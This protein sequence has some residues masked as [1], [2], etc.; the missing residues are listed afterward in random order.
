M[1]LRLNE[2]FSLLMYFIAVIVFV[3]LCV[4][5][6][7]F[8]RRPEFGFIWSY[9]T[10]EVQRVDGV[11]AEQAG[12]TAGSRI[13]T[14][15]GLPVSE[16]RGV[17]GSLP[18]DRVMIVLNQGNGQE[19][20][21]SLVLAPPSSTE[22]VNRLIVVFI[23]FSYWAL[24]LSVAVFGRLSLPVVLFF[25]S[26]QLVAGILGAGAVSAFTPILVG[27]V[28]VVLFWAISPVLLHLHFELF[29][30]ESRW[31][32]RII[33][34]SY[35]LTAVLAVSDI[36]LTNTNQGEFIK[37]FQAIWFI[38]H[39]IGVVVIT[40][41]VFV[42]KHPVEKRRT[43]ALISLSVFFGFMPLV[44]F[45]ML[46]E[47][48]T[49]QRLAEYDVSLISLSIV[50]LGYSYAILRHR[51][52]RFDRYVNRS[53]A[54]FLSAVLV[55]GIYVIVYSVLQN[56]SEAREGFRPVL[57]FLIPLALSFLV[58]PLFRLTQ[59][60]INHMF[61]GEWFDDMAIVKYV[62]RSIDN[63][64]VGKLNLGANLCQT[65]VTTLGLENARLVL[66]DGQMVSS[67]GSSSSSTEGEVVTIDVDQFHSLC[68]ALVQHAGQ[69]MGQ[70]S[71]ALTLESV[72]QIPQ[73]KILFERAK[74][75]FL[76]RSGN[77]VL[78]LL[79]LG[80]KRGG[81]EYSAK[82][83]EVL[84]VSLMQARAILENAYLI[85]ELELQAENIKKLH[86][87]VM[88]SREEERKRIARDLHDQTIQALVG[89]NYQIERVRSSKG[90]ADEE[91]MRYF[92]QEVKKMLDEVRQICSALRPPALDSVGLAPAIQ[93][94][95]EELTRGHNIDIHFSLEGYEDDVE[96]ER[97]MFCL[98]RVFQ[99]A[100]TNVIKH[101]EAKNAY[102]S[103]TFDDDAMVLVVEDDGRGFEVPRNLG[104]LIH[105]RHFGLI[106]IQEMVET[107][108]GELCIE[109]TPGEG[110][111]VIARVPCA[112][113]S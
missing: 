46:P 56:L 111:K 44:L 96:S 106:G 72:E 38:L 113:I 45:S 89:F 22:V 70:V 53:A 40:L 14:I 62:S 105:Q 24:G 97:A 81:G 35:V 28:F 93:S 103:L 39:L 100:T 99:E 30:S 15:D 61:Y 88:L 104:H 6:Y 54:L 13:I 63:P 8:V 78:G 110:C 59:G 87:E 92:Q 1:I 83:L 109:S 31:L 64:S 25:F 12:I 10:G 4:S 94:R 67:R 11:N 5:G 91:E 19:Q 33:T 58:Q 18:G 7:L 80:G 57:L 27:W 9:R 20:T 37:N 55:G 86:M 2:R 85:E 82:D 42:R 108:G 76:L 74:S 75:W 43:A 26:T 66:R 65:L 107:L 112:D 98:Y 71:D 23:A 51:L 73:R 32:K 16:V 79:I 48:I 77:S 102:I 95:I 68:E 101:A 17:P 60:L 47:L 29:S 84:E 90:G 49:G 41:K 36:V 3:S 34:L 52:I 21:V 69:E 50:P